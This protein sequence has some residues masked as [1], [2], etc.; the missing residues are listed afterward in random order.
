[1]VKV[2]IGTEPKI[3][4]LCCTGVL[5]GCPYD[6]SPKYFFPKR[7]RS[8]VEGQRKLSQVS[9]KGKELLRGVRGD[10][11]GCS[12]PAQVGARGEKDLS[13]EPKPGKPVGGQVP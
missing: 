1:V 6:S 3:T 7:E 10:K 12:K 9:S 4:S 5:G 2:L 13:L 8:H 11:R